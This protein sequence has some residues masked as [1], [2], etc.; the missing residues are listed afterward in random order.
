MLQDSAAR[1]EP[2]GAVSVTAVQDARA[3]SDGCCATTTCVPATYSKAAPQRPGYPSLERIDRSI[4]AGR[5]S[6]RTVQRSK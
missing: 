6:W 1:E 3:A 4:D 5:S 2:N